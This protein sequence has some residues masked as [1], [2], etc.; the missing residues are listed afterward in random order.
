MKM[1]KAIKYLNT[2]DPDEVFKFYKRYYRSLTNKQIYYLLAKEG[3]IEHTWGSYMRHIF[4]QTRD[5][6][7]A[8]DTV[9]KYG[10]S[11]SKISRET[12]YYGIN[13]NLLNPKKY[14]SIQVRNSLNLPSFEL[15]SHQRYCI[16][17]WVE[18]PDLAEYIRNEIGN[19]RQV[20]VCH[21]NDIFSERKLR[22]A[23]KRFEEMSLREPK[24]FVILYLGNWGAAGRKMYECVA[25]QFSNRVSLI[26]HI[27]INFEHIPNILPHPLAKILGKHAENNEIFDIYEHYE[28]EA[29]RP[30]ELILLIDDT[31]D[32][33]YDRRLF[34]G[35]TIED[36]VKV[37]NNLKEKLVQSIEKSIYS[38]EPSDSLEN[39]SLN[40]RIAYRNTD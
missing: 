28:M 29:L 13:A 21:A 24:E 12:G 15:W 6:G 34:P 5:D 38:F 4:P 27:G 39:K 10:E 9:K 2:N 40:N 23:Y 7:F 14:L 18:H 1:K 19:P 35:K 33:Y 3:L 32:E 16:E 8:I 11:C 31:I 30:T 36:W 17:L 26:R 25:K 20:R 37:F 22:D